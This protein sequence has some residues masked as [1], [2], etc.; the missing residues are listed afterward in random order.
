MRFGCP[1]CEP[2]SPVAAAGARCRISVRGLANGCRDARQTF[3]FDRR[4]PSSV[5][6]QC[7]WLLDA[8]AA[9]RGV[10]GSGRPGFSSHLQ[11]NR[12]DLAG[13]GGPGVPLRGLPGGGGQPG[14]G[15]RLGEAAGACRERM[16]EAP[17][18]RETRAVPEVL[19]GGFTTSAASYRIAA[20]AATRLAYG[21][22][23]CPLSSRTAPSSR[24]ASRTLPSWLARPGRPFSS[25]S[26]ARRRAFRLASSWPPCSGRPH[27]D[28]NLRGRH[29][30]DSL[31]RLRRAP[32]AARRPSARPG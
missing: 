19:L 5:Q 11:V 6:R 23:V 32:R 27:R 18:P 20:I 12:G 9:G 8:L 14:G 16:M 25:L 15:I 22:T 31:L 3:F 2:R 29:D 30:A 13:Q 26:R 28:G 24:P 21:P 1:S 17:P 7:S 10:T 4:A